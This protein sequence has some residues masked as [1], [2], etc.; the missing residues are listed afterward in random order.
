VYYAQGFV[1]NFDQWRSQAIEVMEGQTQLTC[2][3]RKTHDVNDHTKHSSG[4]A[5]IRCCIITVH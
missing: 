5:N 2:I 4:L 3:P 1:K